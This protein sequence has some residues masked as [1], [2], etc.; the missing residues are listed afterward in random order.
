MRDW[1]AISGNPSHV[2]KSGGSYP[3]GVAVTLSEIAH[4]IVSNSGSH[5]VD[6]LSLT[7]GHV[8]RTI[9]TEGTAQC[10][11][12]NP[13]GVS[14]DPQ[15]GHL[16]VSDS[17][18]HRIQVFTEEGHFVR[19]F[20][21]CRRPSSIV[22][23]SNGEVVVASRSTKQLHVYTPEGVFCR[24]FGS[25]GDPWQ[26]A[27]VLMEGVGKDQLAV[28]DWR[29]NCVQIIS[30]ADGGVI[31]T[32]STVDRP[33]GVVV[34]PD[35]YVIVIENGKDSVAVFSPQG[36]HVHQWG[37]RGNAP[38]Q[39]VWPYY[40]ALLPDGRVAIADSGNDRIQLF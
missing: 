14:V 39:F 33:V 25:F 30:A 20:S 13:L 3:L 38:G 28:S 22:F 23:L 21:C 37:S 1:S 7:D 36:E 6:I 18:N 34:T 9:G 2:F 17:S 16:W 19:M 4:V 35:Q 12:S 8:V 31:R 40:A 11:F 24:S 32:L 5:K 10:Q 29:N 27:V 15:N 26:V